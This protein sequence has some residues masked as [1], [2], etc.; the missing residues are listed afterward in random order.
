MTTRGTKDSKK[1]KGVGG[2]N[3]GREGIM[4]GGMGHVGSKETKKYEP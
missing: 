1:H 2:N 4:E 3:G